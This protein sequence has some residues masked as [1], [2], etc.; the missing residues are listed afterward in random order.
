MTATK[1]LRRMLD[2][3]GVEWYASDT[4][5][6]LV[7]SWNGVNGHSWAFME[8]RDGNFSKLTAYH[9]TPEQAIDAT[10]GCGECH[11]EGDSRRFACSG[12]G[13][14]LDMADD[15]GEPTMWVDGTAAVPRYC[16]NCGGNVRSLT[17]VGE[18]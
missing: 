4:Y 7:T 14:V 5:R 12:C 13:C 10:L 16:P 8:H 9:L 2:E 17:L 3:R 11:D 18:E 6:L 1:E 15:N